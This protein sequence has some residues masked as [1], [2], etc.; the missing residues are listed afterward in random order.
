LICF[1]LPDRRN[2]HLFVFPEMPM[3]D[4]KGLEEPLWQEEEGWTTVGWTTGSDLF[5]LAGQIPKQDL[6]Q[7][8]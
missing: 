4:P 7:Y 8:L 3:A 2:V 5:M 6:R 1:E